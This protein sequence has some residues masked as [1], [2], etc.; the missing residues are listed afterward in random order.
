MY[1]FSISIV[2]VFLICLVSGAVFASS[3]LAQQDN[4][5]IQ[6]EILQ[7]TR[8]IVVH[9]PEN[10]DPDSKEGY[11]VLYMLDADHDTDEIAARTAGE[12]HKAKMTPEVIVIAI[13]NIRRGYDF[14]PPS[15]TFEQDGEQVSGNG[16]KFLAFIKNELIPFTRKKFRTNGRRVFVGHSWGGQFLA[17]TLSQSPELFDGYFITSPSIGEY[18]DQ[19]FGDLKLVF[20]QDLDFPAFIYV[21]VGGSEEP[22][23]MADYDRLTT[24][25]EQ[26]LPAQVKLHIEINEG[27]THDDSG[28][29]S[30]PTALKMYFSTTPLSSFSSGSQSYGQDELPIPDGP[31]LGQQPPG[32]TPEVFAPGIVSTEHYELNGVFTPDMK[33]FYLIRDGGKYEK[34]TFVVFE[35]KNNRWRE[36]VISPRVGQPFIAP[37]GKT[38]HLGRRYK[39]RTEA[40]WSEIKSLGSPFEDIRIMRL[41]AS[42]AGTYYLDEA[43]GIMRYSRLIDGKYEEPKALSAEINL[44][45]FAAHPFIAPDESYLIWDSEKEEGHGSNDLYISFR[46]ENGSWGAA[47][48][49]GDKINT[50][51]WEAA[52]NVTPDGKYLFFNRNMNPDNYEN[53]DIFWVDAQIIETLRPKE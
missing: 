14:A 37:D 12:Y 9:L 53:V 5:S 31:Y 23:L 35:N 19:T 7:E 52:A 13:N 11:P 25:L 33:E 18:G 42:A 17:Y 30:L 10:Y 36:R 44:G 46:Q 4:F 20:K 48:N 16:D 45:K 1:K 29:I 32:S 26:H 22:D 8:E 21:S 39:E 15:I 24:V 47:I 2:K 43:M 51:A 40:G 6:S 3:A 41:T 38:M 49:M 34:S 50:G 28:D 27:A